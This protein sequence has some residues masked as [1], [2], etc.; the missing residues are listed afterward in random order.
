V[1]PGLDETP[2]APTGGSYGVTVT[3][4]FASVGRDFGVLFTNPAEPLPQPTTSFPSV[5]SGNEA[6]IQELYRDILG[7]NAEPAAVTAWEG[8]LTTGQ[9]VTDP[10]SRAARYTVANLIWNSAEH[11]A[12]HVGSYY[13]TFLGR[14][15]DAAAQTAWVNAMLAGADEA[16]VVHGILTSAEY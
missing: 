2:T 15:A 7:R 10:A 8:L 12:L 11:R 9:I 5:S 16:A 3:D 14:D 13:R 1:V 4:G 6:Y